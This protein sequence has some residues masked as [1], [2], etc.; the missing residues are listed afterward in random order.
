MGELPSTVYRVD[1]D[2]GTGVGR[3]DHFLG[4]DGRAD[5]VGAG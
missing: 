1:A 3:V 2:H 4:A 5:V